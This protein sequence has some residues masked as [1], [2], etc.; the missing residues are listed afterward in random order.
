MLAPITRAVSLDIKNILKNSNLGL[1]VVE[2]LRNAEV[3][4]E[5][6]VA[7]KEL[8]DQV[9]Q[10]LLD[11]EIADRNASHRTYR[12]LLNISKPLRIACPK[13]DS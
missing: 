6:A 12:R 9:A 5:G 2:L 11:P 13:A 3:S 4:P 10:L 7:I 8:V 1:L